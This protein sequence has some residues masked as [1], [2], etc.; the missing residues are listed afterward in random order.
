MPV[1]RAKQRPVT[2]YRA[3]MSTICAS[4][5][6]VFVP[7]RRISAPTVLSSEASCR[8]HSGLG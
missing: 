5:S 7:E 2:P 4:V 3:A 1:G 8:S 6:A